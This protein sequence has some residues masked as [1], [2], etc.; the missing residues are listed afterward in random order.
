MCQL[1]GG[2]L[3]VLG[4]LG[5]KEHVRCRNCGMMFSRDAE[6]DSEEPEEE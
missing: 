3:E 4:R 5:R 2:E 1:C 6:P